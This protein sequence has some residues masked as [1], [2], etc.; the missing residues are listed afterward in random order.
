MNARFNCVFFSIQ[1]FALKNLSANSLIPETSDNDF[2][3]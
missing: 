1:E 3:A 2:Q